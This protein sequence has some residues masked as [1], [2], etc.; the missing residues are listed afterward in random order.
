MWLW[1]PRENWPI[2][3]QRTAAGTAWA[4]VTARPVSQTWDFGDGSRP[5]V[6]LGRGTEL[7]AADARAGRGLDGSPDCGYTYTVSSRDEPRREYTV[8][9]TVNWQVSWVGSGD[10]GGI[11]PLMRVPQTISY[12]VR[13]ARAQ[14]VEP[15]NA[16]SE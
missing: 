16:A 4:Q 12:T 13:Q 2:L 15:G 8:R 3:R 9:V 1:I 11:L 7:T 6:C 5:L 10:T 14:L